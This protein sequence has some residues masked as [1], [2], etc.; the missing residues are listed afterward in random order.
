MD[1]THLGIAL[2]YVELNPVRAGI[3]KTAIEYQ[4]SSARAHTANT[5][6]PALLRM[7]SFTDRFSTGDWTVI[8]TEKEQQHEELREELAAIRRA[9][10]LNQPFAAADFIKAL[11]NTHTRRLH[12]RPPGRPQKPKSVAA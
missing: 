10:R 6:P 3:T 11:E 1:E 7:K 9:T 8:L 12:R 4:W 5:H 2:A